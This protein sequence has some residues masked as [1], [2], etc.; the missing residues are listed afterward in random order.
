MPLEEKVTSGELMIEG[1][2]VKG[3]PLTTNAAP[4]AQTAA[5]NPWHA[6]LA[7]LH[8]VPLEHSVAET[9]NEWVQLLVV[10]GV[11][12]GSEVE[13]GGHARGPRHVQSG[14]AVMDSSLAVPR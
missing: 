3:P 6:S 13:E 12:S 4:G 11:V 2:V 5:R 14:A 8:T 1:S 9:K 10:V 7:T